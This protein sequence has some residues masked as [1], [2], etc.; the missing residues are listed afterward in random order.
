MSAGKINN[1]EGS[2]KIEN[3]SDNIITIYYEAPLLDK[4]TK[5]S[6]RFNENSDNKISIYGDGPVITDT[7]CKIMLS[8]GIAE[9]SIKPPE[10]ITPYLKEET[11]NN[12]TFNPRKEIYSISL[13]IGP[14]N[15]GS[16]KVKI[17]NEK[18]IQANSALLSGKKVWGAVWTDPGPTMQKL[19][20]NECDGE[21]DEDGNCIKFVGNTENLE[22]NEFT[23]NYSGP[24]TSNQLDWINLSSMEREKEKQTD[25]HFKETRLV[26]NPENIEEKV[27]SWVEAGEYDNSNGS[28]FS[29]T[30]AMIDSGLVWDQRSSSVDIN[31]NVICN[32]KDEC[33]DNYSEDLG[34]TKESVGEPPVDGGEPDTETVIDLEPCLNKLDFSDL[35][36]RLKNGNVKTFVMFLIYGET[37]EEAENNFDYGCQTT[38]HIIVKSDRC[39]K[40]W[41]GLPDSTTIIKEL[42][43]RGISIDRTEPLELMQGCS[44]LGCLDP[45][46]GKYQT[47]ETRPDFQNNPREYCEWISMSAAQ[48]ANLGDIDDINSNINAIKSGLEENKGRN[49]IDSN[50]LK[51]NWNIN[52]KMFRTTYSDSDP[53]IPTGVDN[54]L[55]DECNDDSVERFR[56]YSIISKIKNAENKSPNGIDGPLGDLYG[57]KWL[58]ITD[59]NCVYDSYTD[60]CVERRCGVGN[61]GENCT[62]PCC[63]GACVYPE[64]GGVANTASTDPENGWPLIQTTNNRDDYMPIPY[65]VGVDQ[66]SWC[67]NEIGCEYYLGRE[68][69][70][71]D[72]DNYDTIL[73]YNTGNG[74]SLED[75]ASIC[76][77][78][79]GPPNWLEFDN[80]SLSTPG[81]G[82]ASES[83]GSESSN[84]LSGGL[85][86]SS[87]AV[88]S[89]INFSPGA[90]YTGPQCN[91]R[92]CGAVC[93]P[94]GGNA[95]D[96]CATQPID[97][98]L[99]RNYCQYFEEWN[100][101]LEICQGSTSEE[102]TSNRGCRWGVD[103]G[104]GTGT[105]NLTACLPNLC[106]CENG[107]AA[108][109][110]NCA[111]H[112]TPGCMKDSCN[113]GY[114]TKE[115]PMETSECS[116][117][118][119]EL[120]EG[121]ECVDYRYYICEETWWHKFGKM[122][123]EAM[124]LEEIAVRF[125][126][127]DEGGPVR[128]IVFLCIL[129]SSLIALSGFIQILSGISNPSKLMGNSVTVAISFIMS[130]I[131]YFGPV[132]FY[133]LIYCGWFAFGCD[134]N[135]P[136]GN[137]WTLL[138]KILAPFL[139]IFI[140]I[141]V[142]KGFISIISS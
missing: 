14:S 129:S 28:I 1:C 100:K 137:A 122:Y 56:G 80:R 76:T 115:V 86:G 71:L 46:T 3:N 26:E 84:L 24:I 48:P 111:Q 61:Q 94:L 40:G 138:Y 104:N 37:I 21:L 123:L 54:E 8:Q 13:N 41:T 29:E 92:C 18:L 34:C 134:G 31:R 9:C 2:L 33:P 69:G 109:G 127:N 49:S 99:T 96:Q 81:L 39:L 66:S 91:M 93:D 36:T 131:I 72:S 19:I 35:N 60:D 5:K 113:F 65:E 116:N 136:Y 103:P 89:D 50:A 38:I 97:A 67:K 79:A 53:C 42:N 124:D 17:D 98:S 132:L 133:T 130:V 62:V 119:L 30:L 59:N 110:R 128:S 142:F 70:N 101:C 68:D 121:E 51:T 47:K 88:P 10:V 117:L 126:G 57:R 140:I 139:L 108:V 120:N 90:D 95:Q 64:R 16:L 7:Q 78:C 12:M 87:G 23:G 63:K 141:I 32:N 106:K 105:E 85:I 74:G 52:T 135:I 102:C 27:F 107:V 15:F 77:Q 22:F 83:G 11:T 114:Y 6:M 20:T 25:I 75:G 73:V 45:I 112:D 55:T 4:I 58:E 82:G 44:V 43:E 118:E 125:F